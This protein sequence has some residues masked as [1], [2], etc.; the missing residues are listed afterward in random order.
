[1]EKY[2]S[3]V[4]F[5]WKFPPGIFVACRLARTHREFSIHIRSVLFFFYNIHLSWNRMGR[6]CFQIR[7]TRNFWFFF[8]IQARHMKGLIGNNKSNAVL[9]PCSASNTRMLRERKKKKRKT[10]ARSIV[11]HNSI[12]YFVFCRV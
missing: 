5:V 11:A 3:A 4:R 7:R 12:R 6:D 1:M 10:A 8:H 9:L 2:G